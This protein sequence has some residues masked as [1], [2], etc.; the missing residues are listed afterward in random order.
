MVGDTEDCMVVLV[1]DQCLRVNAESLCYFSKVV[2][3]CA[4]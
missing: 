3:I 4:E 2:V 1:L